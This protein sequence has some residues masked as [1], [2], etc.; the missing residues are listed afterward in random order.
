MKKTF[1]LFFLLFSCVALT[2]GQQAKTQ[3]SENELQAKVKTVQATKQLNSPNQLIFKVNDEQ[4]GH[5]NMATKLPSNAAMPS[6][7]INSNSKTNN[8]ISKVEQRREL[9]N[10]LDRFYVEKKSTAEIEDLK[11]QINNLK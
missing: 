4:L 6:S 3:I 2:F 10:L 11:Q 5:N 9:L 7:S 8:S 1:T